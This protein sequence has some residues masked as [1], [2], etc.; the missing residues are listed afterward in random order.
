M[1]VTEF[2]DS[3]SKYVKYN[4]QFDFLSSQLFPFRGSLLLSTSLITVLISLRLHGGLVRSME[5]T[6]VLCSCASFKR[7]CYLAD[8]F[9][10]KF[11]EIEKGFSLYV[12]KLWIDFAIFRV[13][14]CFSSFALFF[15]EKKRKEWF[16]LISSLPFCHRNQVLSYWI[17]CVTR[18]LFYSNITRVEMGIDKVH[19]PFGVGVLIGIVL[20]LGAPL[21]HFAPSEEYDCVRLVNEQLRLLYTVCW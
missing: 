5:W 4:K 2:L 11:L 17:H 10:P 16:V 18:P 12:M 7:M 1:A 3:G 14:E 13:S 19:F 21:G 20:L 8:L 9:T 6:L 15:P